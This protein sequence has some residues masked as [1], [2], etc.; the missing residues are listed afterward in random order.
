MQSDIPHGLIAGWLIGL[1]PPCREVVKLASEDM[2]HPLP[3]GTRLKLR[4]HLMICDACERYRRQLRSI[5]EALRR[6]P[7]KLLGQEP[8]TGLSP[9]ARERLKRALQQQKP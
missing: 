4:L 6:N 1:T 9:E 8:S 3:F 7:D 2:N 5:R